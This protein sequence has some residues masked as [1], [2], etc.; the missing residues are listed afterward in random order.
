MHNKSYIHRDI[1]PQNF[2]FGKGD[3]KNILYLID[4]GLSKKYIDSKTGKHIKY[5][6]IDKLIG[7]VKFNSINSLIG[8]ELSRRDDLESLCYLISYLINGKLPWYKLINIKNKEQ[9]YKEIYKIKKYISPEMLMGKG[10]QEFVLFFEYCKKLKFEEKPNYDYLRGLMLQVLNKKCFYKTINFQNSF[11]LKNKINNSRN[12]N[13]EVS[14]FD[15]VSESI[16][17]KIGETMN[18][19]VFS[20][21]TILN[22]DQNP[23]YKRKRPILK[24][25]S[26]SY[27]FSNKLQNDTICTFSTNNTVVN[28]ENNALALSNSFHLKKSNFS[29]C[30]IPNKKNIKNSRSRFKSRNKIQKIKFKKNK[31]DENQCI[32]V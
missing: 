23:L 17:N 3:N 19:Y 27:N 16:D 21:I 8:L 26:N 31:E 1:K 14:Y 28:N 30:K 22:T 2:V 12:K 15:S 25:I 24:L 20:S 4:Y 10:G 13:N 11:L 7:T 32:L 18:N 9:K 5:R 6:N 29:K